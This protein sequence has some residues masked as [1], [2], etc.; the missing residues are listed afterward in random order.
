MDVESLE[1]WAVPALDADPYARAVAV[2]PRRVTEDPVDVP[3]AWAGAVATSD[4]VRS[5]TETGW[6]VSTGPNPAGTYAR[7]VTPDDG[8]DGIRVA[9][10]N[11]ALMQ[12]LDRE[13][14][15]GFGDVTAPPD[16]RG[17]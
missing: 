17:R 1:S 6:T 13:L 8:L 15:T 14:G 11:V 12:F 16:V 2:S 9:D 10:L 4:L 3:V 5:D 7:L